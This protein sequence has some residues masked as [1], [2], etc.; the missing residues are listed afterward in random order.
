MLTWAKRRNLMGEFEDC[1]IDGAS[2]ICSYRC[3]EC[4]KP[5]RPYCDGV[6]GPE[7][8]HNGRQRDC[9]FSGRRGKK[10]DLRD[11]ISMLG[12]LADRGYSFS[13]RCDVCKRE[14]LMPA[15]PV[16]DRLGRDHPLKFQG[17]F[18]CSQCGNKD[19]EVRLSPPSEPRGDRE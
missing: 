4:G 17:V 15:E 18:R 16:S 14:A 10:K 2:P 12:D 6:W 9:S 3:P 11:V 7:F 1:H 19:V 5:V 13:L 8:K